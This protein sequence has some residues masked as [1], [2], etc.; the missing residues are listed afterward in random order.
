MS[1]SRCSHART[2]SAKGRTCGDAAMLRAAV[3]AEPGHRPGR[4]RVGERRVDLAQALVEVLGE[5]GVGETAGGD[6]GIHARAQAARGDTEVREKVDRGATALPKIKVHA[7]S[8]GRGAALLVAQ[9]VD[10]IES[11]GLQGGV[12]TEHHPHG[13]AD[14]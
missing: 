4:G 12:Q 14:Q 11:R 3:L 9:R 13:R 8:P 6:V 1:D 5:G 2:S 7:E 10:R